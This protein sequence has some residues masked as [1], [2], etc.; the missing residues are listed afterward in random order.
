MFILSK[1]YMF[2]LSYESFSIFS[3]VFCQKKCHFQLKQLPVYYTIIL[4]LV[5][6]YCT[7]QANA[8]PQTYLYQKIQAYLQG[9]SI[10]EGKNSSLIKDFE[11][12][13]IL[14][15]IRAQ[16]QASETTVVCS[17][18]SCCLWDQPQ[19]NFEPYLSLETVFSTIK[20]AQN[21]WNV[22]IPFLEN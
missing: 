22:N 12:N 3:D 9:L 15:K 21:F 10:L 1:Y 2:W 13:I 16:G 4:V 17:K 7:N 5:I 14:T 18:N 19:W 11:N 8:T 6:K 20:L